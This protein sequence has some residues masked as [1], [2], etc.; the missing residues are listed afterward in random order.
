MRRGV[1]VKRAI[2]IS[3]VLACVC[4]CL[5]ACGGPLEHVRTDPK[6]LDA[7]TGRASAPIATRAGDEPVRI[8]VYGDVRGE[9]ERH[10]K[11]VGAIRAARP[12]L[13]VFTGD[14][15]HCLPVA[16]MP[17]FGLATYLLPFWP[18]YIRGYPWVTALT[19]VPFP[20]IVHE[21]I[22]RPFAGPRDPDGFNGFLEDTAPIRLEDRTPFVFVPGNHD[23]Y[24]RFDRREAARL[25]VP[26]ERPDR[27]EDDL[28]FAVEIG[29]HRVHVLDTGDDL[30]GDDDPISKGSRQLAWLDAS[31]ADAEK[32]G[33]RSI[34]AMHLPPYSS[35]AEDEPSPEVRDRI[36]REILDKHDVALVVTGHSHAYE[37]IERAGK[38][39]RTVTYVVTG[40][41]GAPFHHEVAPAEREPGSKAFVEGTTHFVLLELGAGEIRGRMVPVEGKGKADA[42]VARE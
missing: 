37:R 4:S 20:A 21:T 2:A 17:D 19:L 39:G 42:F 26:N 35:G 7:F 16:H 40:G 25:F 13:V 34:V 29:A 1:F 41:G 15:L 10:R 5:C 38:G 31:L 36:A 11:V 30:L 33:L 9:R 18:Q 14:A 3:C 6:W 28:F 32:K 23:L 22:G 8:A 24:H 12:D 27:N